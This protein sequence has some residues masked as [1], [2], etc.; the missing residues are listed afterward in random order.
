MIEP[1][2]TPNDTE[3]HQNDIRRQFLELIHSIKTKEI[4]VK[5][6]IVNEELFR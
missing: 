1:P 4:S 3:R 6:C 2:M 5:L